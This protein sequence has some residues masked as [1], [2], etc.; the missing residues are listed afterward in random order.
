MSRSKAKSECD[1]NEF[2][3]RM[4]DVFTSSVDANIIDE[5]PMAYK[6]PSE[7]INTIGETVKIIDIIKPI[8]NFK[9]K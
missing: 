7:I 3:D 8:Y 5:S 4:K 2:K 6:D 1:L 9:A